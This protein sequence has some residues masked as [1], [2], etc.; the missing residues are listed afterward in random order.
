MAKLLR[1]F[2]YFSL[3][4]TP[5]FQAHSTQY[6]NQQKNAGTL[7][8]N[9]VEGMP[10]IYITPLSQKIGQTWFANGNV[11]E[12][13][14]IRK[15][16]SL[17]PAND[18]FVAIDLGAQTGCFTLLAKY[19]PNS[20]WY[21]FE[22]IREAAAGL[23]DNLALNDIHNAFVF[24]MAAAD[25]SGKTTI[26]MPAMNNWGLS[27][28]GSNVQRFDT[29]EEREIECIDLDT[30]VAAREIKKVHFMKIDTEGS[31]LL[32]LR[33]AK[34]MLMRDHP[35]IV[36][37]YNETNMK[38]CGVRKQDVHT[39]LTEMGYTWKLISSEDILCT[40]IGNNV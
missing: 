25:F 15:F 5:L 34:K 19:F 11:W 28:I 17:L 16:Y 40:P 1:F 9:L 39:F 33:G 10:D 14:L 23:Q 12:K 35:T 18:F 30:F 26:N 8:Y 2:V 20:T 6:G 27:T 38:Q 13:Q 4:V 24:Q 3:G 21:A 32:I 37:E 22:P 31:E 29:V 36:M 7:R